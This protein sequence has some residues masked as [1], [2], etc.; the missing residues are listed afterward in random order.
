MIR[1]PPRSTRTDTLFPYTTLFRSESALDAGIAYPH[2]CRSGRCGACKTRLLSGEVDLLPHTPFALRVDERAHGLVLACRAKPLSD[3]AVKWLALPAASHPV[4]KPPP[5][6][7]G[8]APPTHDILELRIDLK[9][10]LAYAAT[11]K[12]DVWGKRVA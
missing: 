9:A 12:S 2:G 1:R 4:V 8:H 5:V 10:P 7:T 3:T 11:R 6:V